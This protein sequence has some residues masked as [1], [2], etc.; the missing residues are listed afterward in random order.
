M[1]LLFNGKTGRLPP[2]DSVEWM[3]LEACAD[4][5]AW[6]RLL[7]LHPGDFEW[8]IARLQMLGWG[9]EWDVLQ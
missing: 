8:A 5:G 4:C 2:R 9:F 6:S 1:D 7:R 3:V